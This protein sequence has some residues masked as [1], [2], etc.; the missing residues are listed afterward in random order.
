MSRIET[1][2]AKAEKCVGI[3]G[4]RDAD[5]LTDEECEEL[6]TIMGMAMEREVSAAEFMGLDLKEMERIW[7][8]NGESKGPKR[9]SGSKR[10]L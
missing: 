5:T 3:N 4:M 9:L 8:S 10:G 7:T 1:R 6:R 2:I